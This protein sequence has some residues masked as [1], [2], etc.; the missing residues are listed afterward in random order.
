METH[1][2]LS[3]TGKEVLHTQLLIAFCEF[4][5][6]GLANS[7]GYSKNKYKSPRPFSGYQHQNFSTTRAG[8]RAI[9]HDVQGVE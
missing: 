5:L 3:E 7:R 4:I 6:R 8:L 1:S 9:F 2:I